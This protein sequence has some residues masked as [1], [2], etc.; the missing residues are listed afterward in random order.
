M[1]MLGA[2]WLLI[3][4]MYVDYCL[5][6]NKKKRFIGSKIVQVGIQDSV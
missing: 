3:G 6:K 2:L 4:Q 1:A 5:K